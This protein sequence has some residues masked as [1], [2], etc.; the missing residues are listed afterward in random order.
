MP[1]GGFAALPRRSG[2]H[3]GVR[4]LDHL[5]PLVAE[6]KPVFVVEYLRE[7]AAIA[8][9]RA[10]IG[11]TGFPL[12]I[13]PRSLKRLT[14]GGPEAAEA[15]DRVAGEKGKGCRGRTRVRRNAGSIDD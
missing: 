5:A 4:A 11:L 9:A 1:G 7:P 8:R 2:G 3:G 10:I 15:R 14:P 12:Y 6:A 13:G